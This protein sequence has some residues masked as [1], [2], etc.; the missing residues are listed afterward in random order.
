MANNKVVSHSEREIY[1]GALSLMQQMV[2]DFEDWLEYWGVDYKNLPEDE[3][4]SLKYYPVEIVR[5][6]FLSGTGHDGGAS[7]RLKCRELGID[8]DKLVEF[9]FEDSDE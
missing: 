7:T 2:G 8:A 3:K 9:S 4:F 5:E 1:D 6:L